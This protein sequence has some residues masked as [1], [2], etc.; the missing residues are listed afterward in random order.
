MKTPSIRHLSVLAAL[1]FGLVA[2]PHAAHAA[3]EVNG[4]LK[5]NVLEAQTQAPVPGAQIRVEGKALI[6]NPR[7]VTTGDDGTFQVYELPPGSYSVEISYQGV[8]PIRK[9]VVIRQGE[10][11]P[12]DVQWSAELAEQEVTIVEETRRMTRPDQNSTGTVI[13]NDQMARV[14]TNRDYQDI[15]QQVASVTDVS[16]NGNPEIKGANYTQ[17][18]YL[19]DGLDIT[20]PITGTFSANINFDTISS[21]QVLTGGMEAQYNSMGGVINLITDGGSDDWKVNASLYINNAKFSAGNQYG[22]RP[23]Q[24]IHPFDPTPKP[25][26]QAYEGT[27]SVGGPIV[28]HRLWFNAS[29]QY[30]YT[31]STNPAAAPLNVA[32]PP[33]KYNGV[34]ARLKLT[35]APSDKHRIQLSLSGDPAFISNVNQ[36]PGGLPVTEGR[37]EQGGAFVTF[38]YNY[39]ISSKSQ[40]DLQ[41]GFQYNRI[42]TGPMGILASVDNVPNPY[43]TRA[44]TYDATAPGHINFD[45]SSTWYQGGGVADDRR[46]TFQLDPSISLR[47]KAAGTHDAKIGLQSRYV[48]ETFD[49]YTPGNSVYSDAGGGPL[50]K[51]ICQLDPSGSPIDGNGCYQRTDTNP[52]HNHPW[53]Y[54]LGAYIQDKWQPFKR[55]VIVPGIRFDWGITK[56]SVGQTVSNLFGI[57]PRIGA[58]VDLTGDQ[59]TM[60]KA[61]YGRYNDVAN[62]LVPAYADVTGVSKTYQYNPANNQFDFAYQSGG[63]GGYRLD[64]TGR[65]PH[66]DEVTVS[67]NREIFKDSVAQIDY[68]FR[69][70]ANQWDSIELNQI[71]DPTGS[72]VVGYKNGSAEQV[73]R[74]SR[75][76]SNYRTY[77]GIDFTL[78]SRPNEHWDI[79]ASYSLAWLYGPGI[80]TFGQI[81]AAVNQSQYYNP[82]M[83]NF[84]DGFTPNDVRHIIKLRTSWNWKGLNL[85]GFI[86]YQSGTNNTHRFWNANDGGYNNRRSPTGTDPGSASGG[87]SP[88]D[89]K[90]ISEFRTPDFF[91]VNLRAS[92]DLHRLIK[93]HVRIIF[94]FFNLL[95]TGTPSSI[96]GSDSSTFGLVTGRQTPFRMQLGLRYDY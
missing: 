79:Y 76:D 22:S 10:T 67:I 31:E 54:S 1:A 3:G 37:Q 5:G 85:G 64:P 96:R 91:E 19:I 62:L 92:Y 74:F 8:K 18:H 82:R 42:Y 21:I 84:Y 20:D 87:S 60:F 13:T 43:S 51:G 59:K 70:Y 78:E 4:R 71:W 69:R 45:D 30:N 41:T 9:R 48:A 14:A 56:N 27:L 63:A 90:A 15:I 88:N 7:V 12:L 39:F 65:T 53:A 49:S 25:P 77:Q 44:N 35:W 47:G 26:T 95:N 89:V 83:Y 58:V 33:R 24:G 80:E 34:Q 55:L 6:G 2:A 86:T 23:F 29:V 50:E 66:V 94:D 38:L 17:T 28:K 72:R 61:F 11:F 81:N 36:D 75:P 52:S 93:Q 32:G 16:G 57:G 68:T 73:Y 40:F 46:Y